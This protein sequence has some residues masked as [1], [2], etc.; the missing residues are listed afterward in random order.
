MSAARS[1]TSGALVLRGE[2]GIGKTAL[3]EWAVRSATGMRV[4]RARGIESESGVPFAA[5]FEL[6]KPVE[7]ALDMLPE[8]SADALRGAL[9]LG[10]PVAVP[11]LRIG[12]AVLGL[13]ATVAEELPLLVVVDDAHW[14]DGASATAMLFAARR[15]GADSVAILFAV[16]D[17]EPQVP[18]TSGLDELVLDGLDRQ[19]ARLL[20]EVAAREDVSEGVCSQL[21][22]AV[23]GN[24]LALI[25]GIRLLGPEQRSGRVQLPILLRPGPRIERGFSRRVAR[26]SAPARRTLVVAAAAEGSGTAEISS[27]L[28]ELGLSLDFLG[29]A[30]TEGI[31]VLHDE[32]FEFSHPLLRAVAYHS[33]PVAERRAAHLALAR[34][35]ADGAPTR[36]VLHRAAAATDPDEDVAAA[37]ES[38]ARQA[39]A[40]GAPSEGARARARGDA[41]PQTRRPRRAAARSDSVGRARR[42]LRARARAGESGHVGGAGYLDPAR[43]RATARRGRT[44]GRIST[45]GPRRA[46]RGRL[47]GASARS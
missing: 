7:D 37:L 2:A 26:L 4:L 6:V 33:A 18:D 22:E 39:A 11:P 27:A 5:L 47:A 25:E 29:E 17:G 46:C 14:V 31:V 20:V 23:R 3:L 16:R 13:L 44:R 28:R 30:E 19:S 10:P 42:R 8:Q 9:A 36:S 41:E 21:Y 35:L 15:L 45:G 34:S 40:R 32:R 1:G 12:V 38:V 43:V 24:P